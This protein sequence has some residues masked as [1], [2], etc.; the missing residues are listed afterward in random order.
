MKKLHKILFNNFAS[1]KFVLDKEKRTSLWI[2]I[3]LAFFRIIYSLLFIID[4]QI[5][6]NSWFIMILIFHEIL[7]KKDIKLKILSYRFLNNFNIPLFDSL[8][9][10]NGN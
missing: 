8:N 1:Y 3:Y 2:L 4:R 9:Q 10:T 7:K 6:L 5:D